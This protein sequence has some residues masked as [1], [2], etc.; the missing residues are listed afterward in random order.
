MAQ[1]QCIN[2]KK[3]FTVVPARLPTAKFCSYACRGQ[4]RSKNW[5]GANH[6]RFWQDEPRVRNCLHC[7]A[8][9][10]KKKTEAISVFSKR[11]FCSPECI[12]LGQKRLEGEAHPLFN[13][14]S[15]RKDR[16][17]KHGAW[18]RAVI[19]RDHAT[20]QRCGAQGVELHAHHIL[21]FRHHPEKRWE[22]ANGETLCHRCHWTEHSASTANGV[23]SGNILPG[24]AGDNPE[25]SFE[26]K[27]IE[28]VT[29]RGRAYRR[30]DGSCDWCGKFI[31][32]RW[33]DTVGKPHLFCSKVCAGK[34]NA[35]NRTYRVW[36]DAPKAHGSNASTSALPERDD[37]V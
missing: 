20:C 18:A 35:A 14:N 27:F 25:P 3:E 11:K 23:N 1:V 17:G 30:W 22:L 2:C 15:R 33:S 8:E 10:R 7:G 4:W 28:G 6:P 37:I 19:A 16:R 26:R 21:S 12:R 32:K 5:L 13:P 9:Y 34:H 36:K 24:N 29:T 31:S